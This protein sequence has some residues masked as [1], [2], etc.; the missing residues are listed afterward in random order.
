MILLSH[1]DE[2]IL[3]SDEWNYYIFGNDIRKY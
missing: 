1:A 3:G 2:S